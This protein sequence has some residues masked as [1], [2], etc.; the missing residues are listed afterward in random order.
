MGQLRTHKVFDRRGNH[1]FDVSVDCT[2][3][4]GTQ[5]VNC[6]S[7]NLSLTGVELDKP[8]QANQGDRV[9][10]SLPQTGIR[11][12]DAEV[13]RVTDKSTSLNF[14]HDTDSTEALNAWLNQSHAM[15]A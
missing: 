15:A 5:Q 3:I 1:R 11:D 14:A 6:R 8:I 12:L 13:V 7:R 2:I 10:V 4:A 9:K